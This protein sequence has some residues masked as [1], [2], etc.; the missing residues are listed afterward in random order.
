MGR[1]TK[2]TGPGRMNRLNDVQALVGRSR[3]RGA[4]RVEE[5]GRVMGSGVRKERT[6]VMKG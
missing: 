4:R 2:G 1:E 3:R 5:I 6:G